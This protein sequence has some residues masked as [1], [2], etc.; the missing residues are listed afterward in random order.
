MTG[1]AGRRRLLVV[2]DDGDLRESLTEA[3]REAGFEV[4]EARDGAEALATLRKQSADAVLLDLMMPGMDGWEFRAAQKRDPNIANTPVVVLSADGS[5]RAEA[6]DAALFLRKPSSLAEL[7]SA[8]ENVL[9]QAERQKLSDRIAHTDRLV[10]LGTLA[11]GIAH[12]INNPLTVVLGKLLQAKAW[13]APLEGE[14]TVKNAQQCLDDA[15]EC[16]ERIQRIVRDVGLF[17][18]HEDPFF[19]VDVRRVL[20]GALNMLQSELREHANLVC[21]HQPVSPVVANEGQLAQVFVNLLTNALH[22]VS[23]TNGAAEIRTKSYVSAEGDVVVEVTDTGCGIPDALRSV[24]FDPF[25]TTKPPGQGTGLGLS[26]SAGIVRRL[27]GR[28][29]LETQVGGGSTFRV[30]LPARKG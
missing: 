27:G 16:A 10:S 3:L 25:F 30:L 15:R 26:I 2:E 19:P 22:A 18:R 1:V 14:T 7:L 11:A 21:D 24:I 17:A 28:I 20:E 5:S 23:K 8:I 12:E 29:E 13:L 9:S 6:V 4:A